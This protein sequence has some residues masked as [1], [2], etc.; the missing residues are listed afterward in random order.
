MFIDPQRC[1]LLGLQL[2]VLSAG[3]IMLLVLLTASN[4]SLLVLSASKTSFLVMM[5]WW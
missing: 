3:L 4:T 5:C 2:H 1:M